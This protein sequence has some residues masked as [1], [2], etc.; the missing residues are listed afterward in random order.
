MSSCSFTALRRPCLGLQPFPVFDDACPEL[1]LDQPQN[2]SVRDPVLNKPLQPA[3]TEL[4]ETVADIRVEHPVHLPSHD[5]GPER[6]QRLMLAA[7]E[8]R[9]SSGPVAGLRR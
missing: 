3:P 1:F 8:R 5:P 7:V 2:P 9:L 4:P 6:V